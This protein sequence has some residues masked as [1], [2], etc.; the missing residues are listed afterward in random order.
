[1]VSGTLS[2]RW[3]PD[4]RT[5]ILLVSSV[6]ATS[7]RTETGMRTIAVE[8]IHLEFVVSMGLASIAAV[9]HIKFGY[10]SIN[11]S[12]VS[13]QVLRTGRGHARHQVLQDRHSRSRRSFNLHRYVFRSR[14][15]LSVLRSPA[16]STDV[17]MSACEDLPTV[18]HMCR[19][20][21]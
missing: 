4:Q 10:K 13:C 16:T 11:G 7:L 17:V 8:K 5:P 20:G 21:R 19:S 12:F 1:M 3:S 15:P 2:N 6:L 18:T 9:T 14:K